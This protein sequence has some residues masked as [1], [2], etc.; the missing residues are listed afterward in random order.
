MKKLFSIGYNTSAFNLAMFILRVGAGVLMIHHGYD[1]LVKFNQM[2][3]RHHSTR[4]KNFFRKNNTA[5]PIPFSKILNKE[6]GKP[7]A[8]MMH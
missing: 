8:A 6:E 4:L 3:P 7:T 2:A 5:S 1:K